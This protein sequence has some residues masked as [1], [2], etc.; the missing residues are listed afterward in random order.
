MRPQ[1][2][3]E[4]QQPHEF[5]NSD[6]VSQRGDDDD[7]HHDNREL[8]EVRQGQEAR[9]EG[10]N[11]FHRHLLWGDPASRRLLAVIAPGEPFAPTRVSWRGLHPLQLMYGVGDK[12]TLWFEYLLNFD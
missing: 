7:T 8:C 3:P 5:W 9:P 4:D 11:P 2:D 12:L 1:K 6:A 10:V